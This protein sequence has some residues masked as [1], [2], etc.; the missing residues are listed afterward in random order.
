MTIKE[1]IIIFQKEFNPLFLKLVKNL[2]L[3]QKSFHPTAFDE[4]TEEAIINY[5]KS[6]KRIRPFLIYFF[7]E[8]DLTND[9]LYA[10]TIA[11]ELFH[12]AALLQDDVIDGSL[13]RRN[14]PTLNA[15]GNEIS[16]NN[17]QL[18][19]HFGILLADVFWTAAIEQASL[20]PRTIFKEFINMIQRT[21]RGQYLDV[22]GMDQEYGTTSKEDVLAR[23]DLKTAWYT[24][25]SPARLGYMMNEKYDAQSLEVLSLKI[26]ELGR[27]FQIRDDIID[28]IDE[29][30]GKPLFGDI[31]ENQTTWVTLYLKQNYLD[32]FKEIKKAKESKNR[33]KIKLI[34]K[35]IDLIT[36]YEEEFQKEKKRILDTSNEHQNLKLKFLEV[37]NLLKL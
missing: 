33:E 12:L 9:E 13:L 27:L 10:L 19:N 8:K 30:S 23:H 31:F 22:I 35:N 34:F 3:E 11:S 1:K 29:N 4:I 15:I 17:P 36:P 6:G 25:I 16:K 2:L 5:C 32:R 26:R 7:A 21:A 28:C 14:V 20:L 18:G 37:L 24:F